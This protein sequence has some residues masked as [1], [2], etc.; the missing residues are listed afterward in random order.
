M[1]DSIQKIQ[2]EISDLQAELDKTTYLLKIADP[3]GEASRKR[4]LMAEAPKPKTTPSVPKPPKPEQKQGSLPLL[5]VGSGI[6]DSSITKQKEHTEATEI[7]EDTNSSKPVYSALKAQW[8]GATREL[9]EENMVLETQLDENEL[10]NF[11]DYIDRNKALKPVNSGS[12]IKGAASGLIIRKRKSVHETEAVG[13]INSEAEASVSSGAEAS[14]VDAVALLLKHK[15]GLSA[16]EEEERENKKAKSR[17]KGKDSS[18][19]KRVL[20]PSRPDFLDGNPEYEAWVPP[21]GNLF[22]S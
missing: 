19:Q 6:E 20:G 5:P 10:D 12:D 8:L 3:M 9:P 15:H 7:T 4:D 14:A 13:G 2:N 18:K 21:E 16:L 22:S 11:V 17:D 1:H